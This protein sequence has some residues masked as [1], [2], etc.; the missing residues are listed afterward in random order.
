[1]QPE[2]KVIAKFEWKIGSPPPALRSH[3]GA[4][5][6]LIEH[7]LDA[8]FDA[9]VRKPS[10]DRLRITLIDGFCGGGAFDDNGRHVQGTPFLLL[11]AVSKAHLRLNAARAKPLAIDAQF[12]FVDKSPAATA[13][14][15]EQLHNHGYGSRIGQDIFI[16]T[17]PFEAAAVDI[18]EII[19]KRTAN[20]VGR[21]LFLLDQKGYTLAPVSTIRSIFQQFK[22]AECILTFAVDFLIDYLSDRPENLK[23]V[24]PIGLMPEQVR[25][26]VRL[27]GTDGG[28]YAV[29][30][31]LL[32][33][34][35]RS[36]SAEFATPF[37]I[38]S[39][40]AAKD[41]WLVHLSRHA[42]ARNVMVDSHW[43]V[44]N[45]S[46]HQGRGGLEINGFNPQI[47]NLPQF[48]FADYE[49]EQMLKRLEEDVMR[50]L[51][52]DAQQIN[53]GQFIDR[54]V[55]ETPA[56]LSDLE[57]TFGSLTQSRRLAILDKDGKLRRASNPSREDFIEVHRQYS[58]SFGA[59]KSPKR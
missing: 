58:F 53:Y 9:V 10:I 8:Y 7:Y 20:N 13:F 56:R 55:N 2:G 4:K 28:R 41:L 44:K 50:R 22:R 23:A 3:S 46:V 38:R 34:L 24:V 6:R 12:H 25:D 48:M 27:R 52:G 33:H 14:L 5:L 43:A 51:S 40:E 16:H 1:M 57:A 37:F 39:Q 42:T 19:K 26:F 30:R 31:I 54:I 35:Q 49:R 21:S 18:Q 47:D 36:T 17:K 15:L 11:N 32:S 45:H 29:Q 59:P